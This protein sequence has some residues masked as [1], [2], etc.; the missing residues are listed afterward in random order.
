MSKIFHYKKFGILL[1][2]LFFLA[3]CQEVYEPED[4]ESNKKILV[5]TGGITDGPGPY[6]VTLKWASTIKNPVSTGISK[7]S[8]TIYD[9]AGFSEKLKENRDGKYQTVDMQGVVG[10][11]YKIIIVLSDKSRYESDFELLAPPLEIDSVYAEAGEKDF[12]EKS[13]EGD[14]IIKNIKGLYVYADIWTPQTQQLYALFRNTVITQRT[15]LTGIGQPFP[16]P[17]V[18]VRIVR[19]P[20][21]YPLIKASINNNGGQTIKKFPL[22]FLQYVPDLS[23]GTDSTSPYTNF[24]WIISTS[25]QN[26]SYT[27][28]KYYE[29]INRQLKAD[30]RLFDPI[31]S[32]VRGNL[33]CINDSTRKVLGY[34]STSSPAIKNKYFFWFNGAKDII[35]KDVENPGP[36]YD[37]SSVGVP[38]DYWVYPN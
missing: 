33:K 5:V 29:N 37:S 16:P 9:D 36:F 2:I 38:F 15:Y 7:A 24:G 35:V 27:A 10:R 4:I 18:Y 34:F 3:S 11:S 26:L 21:E 23:T 22:A 17:T 31:V 1:I 13:Y 8:V 28:Y 32:Q 20:D 19:R 14:L 12:V 25:S 6:Y 30:L